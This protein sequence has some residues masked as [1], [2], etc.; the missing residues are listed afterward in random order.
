[1]HKITNMIYNISNKKHI[2]IIKYTDIHFKEL[3]L[4]KPSKK[5]LHFP[6]NTRNLKMALKLWLYRIISDFDF[7]LMSNVTYSYM[8]SFNIM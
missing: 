1:M 6:E 7:I 2:F 4:G 5:S 8:L 3:V